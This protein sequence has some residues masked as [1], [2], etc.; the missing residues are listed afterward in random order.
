MRFNEAEIAALAATP[1]E[2]EGRLWYKPP[3][4]KSSSAVSGLVRTALTSGAEWK[5]RY[6]RL[7]ANLLFFW[8]VPP[9][10]GAL[11][12]VTP[13]VSGV[14]VSGLKVGVPSCVLEEPPMGC[15]VLERS[16]AQPEVCDRVHFPGLIH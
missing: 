16:H 2:W 9:L 7:R 4:R 12:G 6:F 8:R 14:G 3:A 5:E 10:D 1:P 13:T 15:L 11:V